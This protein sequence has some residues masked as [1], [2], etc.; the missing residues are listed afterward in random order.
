M[1]DFTKEELVAAMQEALLKHP[2]RFDIDPKDIDHILGMITDVGEGSLRA[3]IERLRRHHNWLIERLARDDEYSANHEAM[4]G[5]RGVASE[6]GKKLALF[7]MTVLTLL[8][9][10]ALLGYGAA[11]VG[12]KIGG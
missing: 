2:C 3:G 7:A 1:A 4:T 9:A 8:I 5:A 11:K 12:F 10:A 6:F